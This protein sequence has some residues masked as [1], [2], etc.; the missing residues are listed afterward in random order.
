MCRELYCVRNGVKTLRPNQNEI[1]I[2]KLRSMLA[3]VDKGIMVPSSLKGDALRKRLDDIPA[4]EERKPFAFT[5][6]FSFQSVASY[7]VMFALIVAVFYTM[8]FNQQPPLVEGQFAVPETYGQE[9]ILIS[10]DSDI[11]FFAEPDAGV[12]DE[13]GRNIGGTLTFSVPESKGSEDDVISGDKQPPEPLPESAVKHTGGGGMSHPLGSLDDYHFSWRENDP[14]DADYG[15][16]PVTLEIIGEGNILL[17]QINIT[18]MDMI[19]GFLTEGDLLVI[20]GSREGQS[21][22]STYVGFSALQP[23]L[24]CSLTQPGSNVATKIYQGFVYVVSYASKPLPENDVPLT[25][26]EQSAN[27]GICYVS[28]IDARTGAINQVG[29]EDASEEISLFDR[30]VYIS[31]S[32][33][34]AENN[35]LAAQIVLDGMRIERVN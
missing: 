10:E 13:S 14:N 6:V 3:E 11:E 22:T 26:L 30:H 17:S 28:A 21:V 4:T 32:D 7:A 20:F 18:D 24:T 8:R 29:F 16:F 19:S 15:A 27:T 2:E 34:S 31:L 25:E 12:P 35:G 23:A 5:R 9:N 1:E 33:G